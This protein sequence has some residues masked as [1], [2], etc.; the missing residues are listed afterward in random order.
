M[1]ITYYSSTKIRSLT[2]KYEIINLISRRDLKIS[3]VLAIVKV[4]QISEV[5]HVSPIFFTP[6]ENMFPL[7]SLTKIYVK[8]IQMGNSR[9]HEEA[10]MH[11]QNFSY[12]LRFKCLLG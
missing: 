7:P 6:Q 1:V 8:I 3:L 2:L 4:L 12:S 10:E 9:S 11:R 5:S